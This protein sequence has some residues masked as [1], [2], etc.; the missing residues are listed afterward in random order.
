M[1]RDLLSTEI[2][3]TIHQLNLM[4]NSIRVIVTAML[5]TI[6]HLK[7]VAITDWNN[8]PRYITESAEV[9]TF[10]SSKICN[11]NIPPVCGTHVVL[12]IN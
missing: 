5:E 12:L 9:I 11:W 2:G 4:V 7:G 10:K 3:V 1:S 6:L 8:L